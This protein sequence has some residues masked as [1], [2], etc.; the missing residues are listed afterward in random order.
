VRLIITEKL[1]NGGIQYIT[2]KQGTSKSI[3]CEVNLNPGEYI[4][5]VEVDWYTKDKRP[6]T[7]SAYGAGSVFFSRPDQRDTEGFMHNVLL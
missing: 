3:Y 7:L 1:K 4:V 2:A 5:H 6:F